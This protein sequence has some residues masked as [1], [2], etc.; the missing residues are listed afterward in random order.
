M[1]L[2][3]IIFI[4]LLT[5]SRES[6]IVSERLSKILSLEI[7]SCFLSVSALMLILCGLETFNTVYSRVLSLLAVFYVVE[8]FSIITIT[9]SNIFPFPE[10]VDNS[11]VV[12]IIRNPVGIADMRS[13]SK[14]HQVI[15]GPVSMF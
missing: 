3:L 12:E 15:F 11:P 10:S 13:H 5:K 6:F 14:V 8:H 7:F 9:I 1:I 2:Y 4:S